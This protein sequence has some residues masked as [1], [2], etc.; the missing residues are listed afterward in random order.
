MSELGIR[1]DETKQLL[2]LVSAVI[3]N[4]ELPRIDYRI[5]WGHILKTAEVNSLQ[6]LM[7]YTVIGTRLDTSLKKKFEESFHA[8]VYSVERHAKFL[9]VLLHNLESNKIHALI[10]DDFDLAGYYPKKEMKNVDSITILVDKNKEEKVETLLVGLGFEKKKQLQ[11]NQNEYYK[12]PG[13][14]IVVKNKMFFNERKLS[15]YFSSSPKSYDEMENKAYLHV[16]DNEQYYI[17]LVT[18]AADNF[19]KGKLRAREL[20]DLWCFCSEAEFDRYFIRDRL[21]YLDLSEFHKMLIR[22]MECWFGGVVFPIDD[23]ELYG[24]ERYILSGGTEGQSA[25]GR[26]IPLLTELADIRE[27]RNTPGVNWM[28]PPVDYMAGMF[29]TLNTYPSLLPLFWVYRL[30]RAAVRSFIYRF[31]KIIYRTK[32]RWIRIKHKFLDFIDG[33]N[34]KITNKGNKVK[35]FISKSI[36]K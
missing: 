22:L 36:K 15:K 19:V 14:N 3:N 27:L 9:P 1:T 2:S 7:Y 21:E 31:R 4:T 16:F 26:L 5:S 28:F 24:V 30:L 34:D 12:N 20:A 25:A 32:N 13:I 29:E 17:Y 8:A 6:T 10:F 18:K 23:R 35:D 33:V 11:K